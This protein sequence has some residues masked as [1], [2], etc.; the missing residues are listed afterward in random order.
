MFII[1][2]WYYDLGEDLKFFLGLWKLCFIWKVVR[3]R[4]ENILIYDYDK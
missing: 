2:V 3:D 1:V 4:L